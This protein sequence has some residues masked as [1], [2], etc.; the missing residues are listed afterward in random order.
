MLHT[1]GPAQGRGREEHAG[2]GAWVQDWHGLRDL[3]VAR[4]AGDPVT[5]ATFRRGE[6]HS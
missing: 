4:G 2:R 3:S 5:C 1:A 6:R